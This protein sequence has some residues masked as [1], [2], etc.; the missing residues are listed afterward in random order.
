MSVVAR[1]AIDRDVPLSVTFKAKAHIQIHGADRGRLLQQVTVAV[2][3]GN[4][5]ANVR[6]V[7]ELNVSRRAVVVNTHPGDVFAARLVLR[8]FLDFRAVFSDHQ[9]TTH[10]ELNAGNGGIRALIYA[11]VAKLALQS[12][13]EMHFV[14][15]RDWLSGLRGMPTHEIADGLSNAA[16]RRSKDRLR[17][18]R[19]GPCG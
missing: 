14:R 1:D 12:T 17:L 6:R 8:H 7:I 9:V 16:M 19:R 13:S 18:L 4:A 11:S 2:R 5:G 3:T 10:A 15:K